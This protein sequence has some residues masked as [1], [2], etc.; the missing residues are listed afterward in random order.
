MHTPGQTL[1]SLGSTCGQA[2]DVF[3][4]HRGPE[5]K[6]SLVGHIK[7]SLQRANLTVFV[8]Y[9]LR[10][11]VMSWPHILATLR[12]ARRVLI[13]LTPAFEESPWCLEEART[14]AARPDAVLPIFIDREASWD[15]G[16]LRAALNEFMLDRDFH[17]L[18]AKEPGLAAEIMMHWRTALD[19]VAGISYL[20]HKSE[21]R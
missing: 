18:R 17:Q 9:E 1:P 2:C 8:D 6:R 7:G 11:G 16:K 3:I 21:S 19:S 20:T 15:A 12:G 4:C 14:A 10:E 5:V 13:L